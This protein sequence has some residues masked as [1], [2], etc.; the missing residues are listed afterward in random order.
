MGQKK[1]RKELSQTKSDGE[2]V[3]EFSR[4]YEAISS[5]IAS[6]EESCK[7]AEH[8]HCE[9]KQIEATFDDKDIEKATIF[10][11]TLKIR[12]TIISTTNV[13]SLRWMFSA[14]ALQSCSPPV[15]DMLRL[16]YCLFVQLLIKYSSL[17]DRAREFCEKTQ[18]A[19]TQKGYDSKFHA[20]LTEFWDRTH[21]LVEEI[22][23]R[24]E[25]DLYDT[26]LKKLLIIIEI[27]LEDIDFC[28]ISKDIL[29]V[30]K[31]SKRMAINVY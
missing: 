15:Q 19:V 6:I 11:C 22:G 23:T 9:D 2:S 12:Q 30:V 20:R 29:E 26:L 31:K 13:N 8:S 17:Q 1:Q 24:V 27:T 28:V 5:N 10:T 7:V 16:H 21:S 14:D 3:F 4:P 25:V 18:R